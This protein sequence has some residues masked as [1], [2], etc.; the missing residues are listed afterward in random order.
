[1]ARRRSTAW[2]TMDWW[3]WSMGLV[4]GRSTGSGQSRAA[5]WPSTRP[6]TVNTG[7]FAEKPPSFSLINLQSYVV[8]K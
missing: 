3:T 2:S 7:A 6:L 5:T 8:Q 1:M 4:Y